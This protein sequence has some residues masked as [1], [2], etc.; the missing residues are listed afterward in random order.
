MQPRPVTRM[1]DDEVD[2][3]VDLVGRLVAAQFPLWADLPIRPVP[4]SGTDNAMYRLGEELVVRMPRIEGAVETVDVERRLLP[5]LAPHLPVAVPVPLGKG[6]A[7]EGYPFPWTVFTWIPGENPVAGRLGDPDLIARELAAVVAALRRIEPD[8][9]RAGRDAPLADRDDDTRAAIDALRGTVDTVAVTAAWEAA[10][11]APEPTGPPVWLHTDLS[12]GNVLLA[13]GRLAAVIDWAGAG[14]GDPAVDLPVAWN[15]LPAAARP[16]F[17][18]ALGVDDATWARGR[19]WALSIALIQLPYYRE[20]NPA[21]AANARH[22][23]AE[24]LAASSM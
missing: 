24:V 16:A 8:G 14:V 20:T 11:R 22:V 17:R 9:P 13:G 19:G 5:R 18:D 15:L 23:I 1:H 21:L 7:G 2:T 12:P 10:L 3:D 4:S 6:V